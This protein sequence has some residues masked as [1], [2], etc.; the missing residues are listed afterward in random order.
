MGK[1][2]G[3]KYGIVQGDHGGQDL[4]ATIWLFHCL[5]VSARATANWAEIAEQLVNI[6]ELHK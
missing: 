1:L 4:L 5:T 3:L 2:V 6:V